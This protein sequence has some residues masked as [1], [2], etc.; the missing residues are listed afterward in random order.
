MHK[1]SKPKR[2]SPRAPKERG[3]PRP[4][5]E[6]FHLLVECKSEAEQR[7]LYELVARRG[8]KCRVITM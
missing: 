3:A 2:P 4:L 8:V 1:P 7:D 6:V 5:P